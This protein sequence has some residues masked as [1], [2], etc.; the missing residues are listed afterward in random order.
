MPT[1]SHAYLGR[2]LDSA[3]GGE[4]G[5]LD[6]SLAGDGPRYVDLGRLEYAQAVFPQED[7]RS[8]L[9]G[10]RSREFARAP[11]LVVVSRLERDGSI[12]RSFGDDGRVI[13][14]PTARAYDPSFA[15]AAIPDGDSVVLGPH[16][17]EEYYLMRLRPNGSVDRSFGDDG[18]I[19]DRLPD[20]S[21][22][23][24]GVHI[25]PN[26]RIL[27][28]S[29][30]DSG[31]H[32]RAYRPDGSR[33]RA[34]GRNGTVKIARNHPGLGSLIGRPDGRILVVGRPNRVIGSERNPKLI[35]H[36]LLPDG[37]PDRAL[38]RDGRAAM[39]IDIPNGELIVDAATVLPSGAVVVAGEIGIFSSDAFVARFT[40]DGQPHGSYGGGDGWRRFDI[41]PDRPTNEGRR[42]AR[43]PARGRRSHHPGSIRGRPQQ[44]HV[45]GRPAQRRGIMAALRKGRLRPKGLRR[46]RASFP[47][48]MPQSWAASW[49][50]SGRP[51]TTCSPPD[52][53]SSSRRAGTGPVPSARASDGSWLDLGGW[54][55]RQVEPMTLTRR[56]KPSWLPDH[57]DRRYSM[58]KRRRV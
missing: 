24:D 13:V 33:A 25:Q 46:I 21:A 49:W 45:P 31:S 58:P 7:G 35:I 39:P 40:A 36:G 42:T 19:I 6:R 22:I 47:H 4:P 53:C 52:S 20:D 29:D 28:L 55:V 2:E 10:Q 14:D 5:E 51:A 50:S 27:V 1:G 16:G 44:R 34:F 43:W 18:V 9:A 17:D 26:G 41:G 38:G 30:S 8:V 15:W 23:L 56:A 57:R 3:H 32:V 11:Y 12:D 54:P 37:S 48:T